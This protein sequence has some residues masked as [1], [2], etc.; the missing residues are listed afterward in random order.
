LGNQPENSQNSFQAKL[1]AFL[2]KN[3]ANPVHISLSSMSIALDQWDQLMEAYFDRSYKIFL[4]SR[5][6]IP[7]SVRKGRVEVSCKFGE[8]VVDAE[9]LSG[10]WS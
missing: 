5:E 7:R 3:A 8:M 4:K 9:K 6:S 10:K 2:D 1:S